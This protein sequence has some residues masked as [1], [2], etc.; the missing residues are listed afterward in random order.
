MDNYDFKTPPEAGDLIFR[1]SR[2]TAEEVEEYST[3]EEGE[4]FIKYA[5][6]IEGGESRIVPLGDAGLDE[7]LVVHIPLK[8][9]ADRLRAVR[10]ALG[11]K[12]PPHKASVELMLWITEGNNSTPSTWDISWASIPIPTPNGSWQH[13]FVY[14][15]TTEEEVQLLAKEMLDTLQDNFG[16]I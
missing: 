15:N 7:K 11:T 5:P 8:E 2:I 16:Q 6:Y 4:D 14:P 12:H 10:T 3:N 13:F 1:R 9:V